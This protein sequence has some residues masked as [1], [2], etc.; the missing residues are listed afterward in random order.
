MSIE[1]ELDSKLT[2]AL[3]LLMEPHI[4]EFTK[5]DFFDWKED[6]DAQFHTRQMCKI[7][8]KVTVNR[9]NISLKQRDTIMDDLY[10]ATS[11]DRR[12]W[13]LSLSYSNM[14]ARHTYRRYFEAF[15]ANA[16]SILKNTT[17]APEPPR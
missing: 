7:F 12:S 10:K 16:I 14:P 2:E 1:R 3:Y 8:Y 15:Y 17:L 4:A 9:D 5:D 11:F 13:G 6:E